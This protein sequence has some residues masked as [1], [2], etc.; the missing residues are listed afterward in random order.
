MM[1]HQWQTIANWTQSQVYNDV[2]HSLL[3]KDN[4]ILF[5]SSKEARREGPYKFSQ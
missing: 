4:G 1:Y 3:L 5:L 2:F